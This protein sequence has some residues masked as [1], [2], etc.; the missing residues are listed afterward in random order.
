VHFPVTTAISAAND[1]MA[2]EAC[3]AIK[4]RDLPVPHD[5]S[6]LAMTIPPAQSRYLGLS[7]IDDRSQE[8]R[9]LTPASERIAT[10]PGQRSARS[11]NPA[12]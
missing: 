1:T 8:V 7:S 2:V 10:Q 5:I 6:F 12:L 9:I 3:A 11:S 4:A